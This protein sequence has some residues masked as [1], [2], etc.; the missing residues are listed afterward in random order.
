[1]IIRYSYLWEEEAQA[2]REE[3][4]RDRPCAVVLITQEQ[5]ENIRVR[6]LPVTHSPPRV[7]GDAVEIPAPVKRRLG[8]DGEPSWIVLGEMNDFAWLGPDVRPIGN[9]G[10][11]VYGFLPPIFF[12]HLLSQFA[13]RRTQ[14]IRR[15]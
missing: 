6:V 10:S 15:S 2:G 8:L 5:D 3:S 11:P 12:E 9:S 1:M 4:I 14:I 7:A 13:K